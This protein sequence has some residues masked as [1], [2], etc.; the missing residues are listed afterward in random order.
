MKKILK[1][2][3]AVLLV[4]STLFTLVSCATPEK[5]IYEAQRNLESYGYTVIINTNPGTGMSVILNADKNDG[6]QSYSLRIMKCESLKLAKLLY[7][8]LKLEIETK[9]KEN[10]IT[11]KAMKHMI[12]KFSDDLT[13]SEISS[14]KQSI[15]NL[16]AENKQLREQLVCT[17][18]SGKY[19]WQGDSASI[20]ASK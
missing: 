6:G 15:I 1:S 7:Q 16:E 9:I 14:Y 2:I 5:D 11:I 13:S 3:V 18:R 10:K 12:N 8:E 4:A 17:G 20:Q 19:V